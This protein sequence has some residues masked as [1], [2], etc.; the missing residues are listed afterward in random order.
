MAQPKWPKRLVVVRH[1]QSEQNITMDILD[2]DLKQSLERLRNIRDADIAL[3]GIGVWQAEETGKYL[4][5]TPK[6]DICFS[7]PYMRTL[8]TAGG[9]ISK[10]GYNLQVYKDNRLREKEF[11]RLHALTTDQIK[12]KYPDEYF[13]RKRDGKY[14]YRLLGG[15]NYPDVEMRIHSFLDKLVRD[16]G[17]KKVL[18]VTHHVPCL[19][20]RAL[21]EHLGEQEVLNLGDI[22]NCGIEEFVLDRSKKPEGKMVLK[23]FNKVAYD[24]MKAP[25]ND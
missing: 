14:W 23:E 13:D 17:G 19:L 21:F 6:F 25:R 3:T 12:E 20:F 22:P 24:I 8:Q 10:I 18:V 15:E 4:S 5:K 7:S 16:Y 9:I 11:G 1:G 2:A